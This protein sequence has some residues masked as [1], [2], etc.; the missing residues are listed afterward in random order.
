ME[1]GF[2]AA[3]WSWKASVV[4]LAHALDVWQH[5]KKWTRCSLRL[6]VTLLTRGID[7]WIFEHAETLLDEPVAKMLAGLS[8]SAVSFFR[9]RQR[10]LHYFG[11]KSLV[12]V[13]VDDYVEDLGRGVPVLAEITRRTGSLKGGMYEVQP[14]IAWILSRK[15]KADKHLSLKEVS[16]SARS[17]LLLDVRDK[18]SYD[19]SLPWY[20]ALKSNGRRR[21]HRRSRW[22]WRNDRS[23]VS[24][25]STFL[26]SPRP[27]WWYLRTKDNRAKMD[28]RLNEALRILAV[29]CCIVRPVALIILQ[30][31]L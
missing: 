2:S 12:F 13:H 6:R 9:Q 1:A 10:A 20:P 31:T 16:V 14:L 26:C 28:E 24:L 15:D 22:R 29:Q 30:Y 25:T 3:A 7:D 11:K 17:A 19:K 21:T 23:D 27:A 4:E 8:Q 18:Q 5:C